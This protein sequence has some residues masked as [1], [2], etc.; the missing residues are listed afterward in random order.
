MIKKNGFTLVELLVTIAILG[1]LSSIAIVVFRG[2]TAGVRDSRRISDLQSIKQA[3]ELYRNDKHYYPRISVGDGGCDY[4]KPPPLLCPEMPRLILNSVASLNNCTGSAI[5][6]YYGFCSVTSTY[7]QSIPKDS[8]TSRN[9]YYLATPTSPI[10]CN[11]TSVPCTG[12]ILCAKKE[13][14]GS[15]PDTPAGCLSLPC[16]SAGNCN[17]GISSQ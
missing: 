11:N 1:V 12:F 14:N 10:I 3:L 9:Y 8:D 5:T 16:G 17:I 2:V 15:F 4:T 7:L 6:N 13:G